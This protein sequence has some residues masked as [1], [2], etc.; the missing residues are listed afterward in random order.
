MINMKV[1]RLIISVLICQGAGLVGSV[2]TVP[3]ISGWY[4]ALLKPSFMPPNW[5]F[6]PVWTF[7]FLFM[8]IALYLVWEKKWQTASV[9]VD[10]GEKYWNSVS[11]KLW[12]GEW[13]EENAIIIFGLQLI[14]NILWSVIFFGLKAP[15][16][17][18]AE[19]L[20]LFFAILYT[21]VNFYRI[22]KLAAFLLLPYI[23][24]VSFAAVLNLF[25]LILNWGNP[26]LNC[27]Y[28]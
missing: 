18:F 13:R 22:S 15:D 23:L 27:F 4:A 9:V 3:A 25:I 12:R 24:W 8:G 28:C 5:I 10:Q 14:L 2:F 20:M 19:I 6:M 1:I 17:A 16:I 26:L 7:L 21:I 11:K